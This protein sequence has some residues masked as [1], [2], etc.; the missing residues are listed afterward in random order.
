M[1][2]FNYINI[3]VVANLNFRKNLYLYNP[4][5][6]NEKVMNKLNKEYINNPAWVLPKI[7]KASKAAFILATWINATIQ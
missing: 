5:Q 6:M 2:I 4:E 7:E 1:I 3:R